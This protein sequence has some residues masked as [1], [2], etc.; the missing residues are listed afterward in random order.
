MMTF[1]LVEELNGFSCSANLSWEVI[2][3]TI[4]E[5]YVESVKQLSWLLAKAEI[6]KERYLISI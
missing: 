6:H 2:D 4:A 5:Q 1:G 3:A